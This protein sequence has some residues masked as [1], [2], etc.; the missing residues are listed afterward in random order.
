MRRENLIARFLRALSGKT[1]DELAGE[2]GV[3]PSLVAQ[4]EKGL[5]APRPELL[6]RMA[7]T[8]ALTLEE[9]GETLRTVEGFQKNR[10]RRGREDEDLDLLG[11]ALRTYLSR[12]RRR[13][14]A[15]PAPESLPRPG[16]RDRA[17]K[18]FERL[19]E[20]DDE[21]ALAVVQV[22]E[23]FQDRAVCERIR[24][25]S[26]HMEPRDPERAAA[27]A[28]LAREIAERVRSGRRGR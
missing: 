21:T 16:D 26:L 22:A 19:M 11:E 17:G 27:L 24:E 3:H 2:V 10:Q 12:T 8:A 14:R 15:L 20:L 1:Q 18:L 4:I 5:I 7:G 6:A 23:E 25:E 13:L 28:R 9:A